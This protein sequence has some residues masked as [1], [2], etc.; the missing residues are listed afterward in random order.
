MRTV[1]IAC[2]LWWSS[3]LA[4]AAPESE[5]SWEFSVL[6][7]GSPIG[8]H[9]FELLPRESG[10]EVRSEAQFDVR[11]LFFNAFQYRHTNREL[12][13]GECL[14]LIE[15]KTRQNG[16]RF[17]VSGERDA[18]GLFLEANGREDRLDGCVMS[19]AYW[20][21]DF[22]NESRLLDPQSG[23]YLSVDVEALG[24]QELEVRGESVVATAYQ[25]K[26]RN[27]D[28]TLWYSQDNEWLGLESVAKGGRI[29]RYV[30]T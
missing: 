6:L 28:M 11:F 27:I 4:S 17:S 19:F 13:D 18:N 12:W 1:A 9:H 30:L 26:A 20:N 2:V 10:L 16:K 25:L 22:L 8:Y 23:E 24:P 7:D 14:R 5:K 3:A 29:I 15:S 21:P